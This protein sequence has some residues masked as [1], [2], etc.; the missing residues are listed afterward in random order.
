LDKTEILLQEITDACGTSGYENAARE[1]MARHMKDYAEIS[2]DKLGSIIGKKKGRADSPRVAV[3]GHLD[4]I[5]FMVKEST[6]TGYIKFLPLGGWWGHVAL[7]QR[8]RIMTSKGPVLGVVGSTPPH[9][10]EPKEREKVLKISDM[11]IDVGVMNKYDITK[12]LGIRV[13]DPII[14][15]SQFT[16][17]NHNKMYMAKAF[18]NRVCCAMVIE[19][20]QKF[21]KTAHPNTIYGIGTVQE[22][23]GLRGARTAAHVTDPD[24]AIIL[25]VNIARDIPPETDYRISE[26]LGGGPGILV[27]DHGMIP[28]QRLRQ[29][30][31]GTAEE[32]NIPYHLSSME[33]GATDGGSIHLS[34]SGVPTVCIGL[35]TRYIHSHNG[36]IYRKDYDNTVR[37]T[38]EIVRK[39]NHKTV[40]SLTA[41]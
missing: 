11:F 33:R 22:E 6:R 36:I 24:V 17:M 27:Y 28:N 1:V 39:L 16:I 9:L 5:G 15:D 32:K 12:K 40:E 41:I 18:D 31:I 21:H 34:R 3:V 19:I 7:A 38:I 37:L 2:Y 10:L 4:E 30:V 35:P 20:L 29:L 13:G 25:D 14:P 8:V 23:V 26:K